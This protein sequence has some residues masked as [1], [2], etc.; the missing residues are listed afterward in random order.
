MT[1]I[2]QYCPSLRKVCGIAIYTEMLC[3]S[4][5][6]Q[7]VRSLNEINAPP[8]HLHLQHEFG[9]VPLRKLKEIIRYCK[10]NE[11]KF[12][13]TM[14]SVAAVAALPKKYLYSALFLGSFQQLGA[15]AAT[16]VIKIDRLYWPNQLKFYNFFRMIKQKIAQLFQT[17]PPSS[18][19]ISGDETQGWNSNPSKFPFQYL[20]FLIRTEKLILENADKIIVH[21]KIAQEALINMGAKCVEVVPHA[22][23]TF[24]TSEHLL[25]EK[26]GR[27]HVGTFGF[28]FS[29]KSF[30]E[31][32]AACDLLDNV[33]LHIFASCGHQKYQKNNFYYYELIEKI[34]THPWIIFEDRHLPMQQV[35]YQ[36]SQNDV[37]VWYTK[38]LATICTSGSIRQYLAAKRPIIA[39]NNVMIYDVKHLIQILEKDSP[40]DLANA[41]KNFNPQTKHIEDYIKNYTWDKVTASYD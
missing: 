20:I 17:L 14:H 7:S 22:I 24:P 31:I 33:I 29:Y 34:K 13:I 19:K 26:D 39:S 41:I 32:I 38:Q 36:L 11:V 28:L 30:L 40:E 4:H 9:I 15:M 35:V 10:K 6:Y 27:L 2:V 25:S 16:F 8:T 23:Q 5:N 18:P 3:Q 21:S 37:N 12:Y 1:K